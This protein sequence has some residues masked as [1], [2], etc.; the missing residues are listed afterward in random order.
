MQTPLTELKNISQS[1][2]RAPAPVTEI[3]RNINLQIDE[4]DSIALLGP[5]GCGK[6]TL[7][8]IMTGLAQ[9]TAGEIFYRGKPLAGIN[10]GISMV[11]QN[12]AL[13]PWMTVRQNV[14]LALENADISENEASERTRDLIEMV[15]LA[16][17]ENMLP[18]ELSGGMKQRVGIARALVTH[19]EILCMDEPFSAL[20]VLTAETLR[21]E[22]GRL[23]ADVDSPVRG[24]AIVT[25]NITEAVYLTRRIVVLAAKPG[26]I[27]GIIQNPLPYPRDPDMPEFRHLAD[28]IHDMLTHAL[29]GGEKPKVKSTTVVQPLPEEREISLPV[30]G[31][32]Q[33]LG[34]LRIVDEEHQDMFQL[35]KLAGRE[36]GVVL[37]GLLFAEDLGFVSMDDWNVI[38]TAE[39]KAFITADVQDQREILREKL[40]V[41]PLFVALQ[42]WI[43]QAPDGELE[44]EDLY[45]HLSALFPSDIPE[46]LAHSVKGWGMFAALIDVDSDRQIIKMPSP[47]SAESWEV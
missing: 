41:L 1:Y 44:D 25:H 13:F 20:D 33:F 23:Y 45:H 46:T 38:R 35:V 40:S 24:M 29:A 14:L 15:G 9:P 4:D 3:L 8:R 42:K 30:L 34:L 31:A 2:G 16:G 28:E 17:Y 47:D 5:S 10:P 27:A 37:E 39:G 21:D 7:L 11:F 18:K 12:F 19:P 36:F 32:T 22:I 43:E 26:C 6:S